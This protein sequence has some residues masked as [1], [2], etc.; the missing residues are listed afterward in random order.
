MYHNGNITVE[1][2]FDILPI[3][4]RNMKF[5]KVNTVFSEEIKNL[6]ADPGQ[7]PYFKFYKHG[8][9]VDHVN[10]NKNWVYQENELRRACSIHNESIS[11]AKLKVEYLHN[12]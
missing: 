11:N 12:L 6:F 8:Q 5:Y 2:D 4:F 9:F 1:I 7:K 10:Y 3:E